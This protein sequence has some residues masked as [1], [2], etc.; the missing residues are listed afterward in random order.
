MPSIGGVELYKK[1]SEIKPDVKILFMTGYANNVAHINDL[2]KEGM[3]ILNKPFTISD[4]KKKI[5]EIK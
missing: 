4:F 3:K 5:S 1:F 2:I